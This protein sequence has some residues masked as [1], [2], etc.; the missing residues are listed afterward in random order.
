M[1][2]NFYAGKGAY[3]SITSAT[4]GT[5]NLS[6]GL[7]NASLNRVAAALDITSFGD[8]DKNYIPGL[9]DA[10]IKLSGIFA[11][12][13]DDK[14]DALLG[15]TAGGSWVY[16]PSSTANNR[17]KKSGSSVITNYTIGSPVGDKVTMSIDLQV[18]G[19]ITS[20]TF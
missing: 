19:T 10:T 7:D 16:G 6:S 2:P 14:L 1:A 11:S 4:G 13:Y 15:S 8:S 20:T 5:I 17:R 9:R 12:T 18:S 3:F